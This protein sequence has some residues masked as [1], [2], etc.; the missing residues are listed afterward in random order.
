ML[1]NLIFLYYGQCKYCFL[2]H[3]RTEAKV[4]VFAEIE[5]TVEPRLMKI[6]ILYSLVVSLAFDD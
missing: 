4:F 6:L 5:L 2:P 1:P 3:K